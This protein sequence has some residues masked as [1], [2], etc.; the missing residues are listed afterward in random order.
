L[1]GDSTLLEGARAARVSDRVLLGGIASEEEANEWDAL[2][3]WVA[4]QG[5]ARGDVAF[6]Y[7]DPGTGEQRAIFDLVWPNGVQVELTEPVAVL[8]GESAELISL[9]S[10]AGYRCFTS[11]SE[12]K[13]Y[14]R[15]LSAVG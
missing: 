1:H 4:E 9:A 11:T 15:K 12:F 2:N 5:F 3:D 13:T 10:A 14:A 8:L 7:V 6:D